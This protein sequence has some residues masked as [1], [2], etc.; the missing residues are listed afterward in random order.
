MLGAPGFL[1]P[2]EEGPK[3]CA[4]GVAEQDGDSAWEEERHRGPGIK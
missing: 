2:F 3:L 1:W 4:P